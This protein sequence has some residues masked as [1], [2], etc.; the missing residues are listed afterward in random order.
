[1]ADVWL[2]TQERLELC[3]L[4]DELGPS[5][6]TLLEGWTARDLA[7][8][9]VLR[10]RDLL[11]GPCLV[12]PGPFGRFAERRRARLARREDFSWLVARIRSGPPV[13]FF[14]L[15]WVRAMANL[16]E[17]FVHH[18]DLR[19]ANGQG[20]RS[21]TPAMDAA[22]WRNVRRGGRYLSRRVGGCGL[23]L[24]WAGTSERVTAVAGEPRVVLSG[25]P[26]ELLLYVFGRQAAA[27]V[28]V[29]GP[30]EAVAA[31]HGTHF[32]M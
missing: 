3:D 13:G 12:L 18:E 6:P 1:M 29:S 11:A 23:E 9:L 21:L 24:R 28:E 19:R 22:L 10:E 26:G 27:E 25:A 5:V 32:G 7:A 16:N 14:R 15:G 2:D 4:F 17:F 20:A 8:H 31:V 30:P